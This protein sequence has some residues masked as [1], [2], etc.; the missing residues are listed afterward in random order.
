MTQALEQRT[1]THEEYLVWIPKRN[2]YTYPDVGE[3]TH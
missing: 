2:L 3:G 1:Y